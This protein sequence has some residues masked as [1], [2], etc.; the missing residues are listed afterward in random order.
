[1]GRECLQKGTQETGMGCS[2]GGELAVGGGRGGGEV[3]A[4]A[5]YL[6]LC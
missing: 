3:V 1:M 5:K 6:L 4:F 2:W